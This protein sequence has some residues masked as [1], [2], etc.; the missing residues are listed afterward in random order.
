MPNQESVSEHYGVSDLTATIEQALKQTG[1]DGDRIDWSSLEP[2]DQ[3]HVRGIAAIKE[4][5]EGLHL[6]P[7]AKV[8]DVGCGIGGPARFLAANYG[9]HVT[10]ID[11]TP[12]FI[13]A[14][15]MLS[16]RTGLADR[17][18]FHQGDALDLVHADATFDA[19][20][21]IHVAMNIADRS[22]LYKGIYTVLH[23]GGRLAIYDVVAGN[24]APLTFPLPWA[25]S[26]DASFLL[27]ADAMRDVLTKTGF[28]VESWEDTTEAGI[29]QFARQAQ[30]IQAS[31]L[32]LQIVIGPE[33]P[34]MVGNLVQALKDGRLRLVQTILV[35]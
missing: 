22:R 34:K 24:G 18:E 10:G 13:D 27:T 26:A 4:L 29:A 31:P 23:S 11:L 21:T 3:F 1:L 35:K 12:R 32:G 19:A 8:L 20:W 2:L 9:V 17:T 30:N 16:E 7:S 25:S 5:A 6:F 15:K 14:A 33:F 28:T